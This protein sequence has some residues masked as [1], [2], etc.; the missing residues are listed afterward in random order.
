MWEEDPITPSW[1]QKL[2]NHKTEKFKL[3]KV[4]RSRVTIDH[5]MGFIT[6]DTER[7]RESSD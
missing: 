6:K 7:E 3:K 5:E 1:M 4:E 2:I